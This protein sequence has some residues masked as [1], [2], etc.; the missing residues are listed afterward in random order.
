MIA[1]SEVRIT[2]VAMLHEMMTRCGYSLPELNSRYISQK[3]LLG[4]REGKYYALKQKDVVWAE[5]T[6]PPP[7]Q[8][9]VEKI[10]SYLQPLGISTGIDIAKKNFP[11]KAYCIRV[12]ASLSKGK[13]E[14]FDKGYFPQSNRSK[15]PH[16]DLMVNNA[17]G[18]LDIPDW[19]KAQ[20]VGKRA[21]KMSTLTPEDK[22]A[23]KLMI[24]DM[25]IQK[26]V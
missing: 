8:T 6:R 19:M 18:L 25:K 15:P 21:L 11:D 4:I 14:I 16:E 2:S 20:S 9:L 26:Q 23:A 3:M 5:C 10:H 13:D 17:D 1:M 12:I 24:A 22:I 7:I